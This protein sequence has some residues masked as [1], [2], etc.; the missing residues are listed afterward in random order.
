M[1]IRKN[2]TH[3]A[4]GFID[5]SCCVCWG[6]WSKGTAA[7]LPSQ[8]STHTFHL[9]VPGSIC[10]LQHPILISARRSRKQ[11]GRDQK[12]HTP[13]LLIPHWLIVI[14]WPYLIA[15]E[16]ETFSLFSAQSCAKVGVLLLKLQRKNWDCNLCPLIH[17]FKNLL[18]KHICINIWVKSELNSPIPVHLSSLIPRVLMFTLVISW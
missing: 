2:S 8:L 16:A 12:L 7:D 9:W 3:K 17:Q 15:R 13:F 5:T 10:H 6:K 1:H 18:S 11:A 14:T 4:H